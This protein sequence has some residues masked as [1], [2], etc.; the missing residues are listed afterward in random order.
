MKYSKEVWKEEMYFLLR[1][2]LR[3]ARDG[4]IDEAAREAAEELWELI[5]NQK[6]E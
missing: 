2:M 5:H 4:E 1:T 3:K 6:D